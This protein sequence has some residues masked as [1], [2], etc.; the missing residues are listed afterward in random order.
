MVIAGGRMIRPSQAVGPNAFDLASVIRN[1][2]PSVELA[3]QHAHKR[4]Q[5]DD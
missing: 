4:T 3:A 2:P 5:A 1:T